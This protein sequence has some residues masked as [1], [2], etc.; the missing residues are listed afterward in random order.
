MDLDDHLESYMKFVAFCTHPG[1]PGP[2]TC[3]LKTQNNHE[4]QRFLRM[5]EPP[6]GREGQ[7][8]PEFMR[9][10]FWMRVPWHDKG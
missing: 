4:K 1:F 8:C 6:E 7:P 3:G 5:M 10:V 2:S 9:G